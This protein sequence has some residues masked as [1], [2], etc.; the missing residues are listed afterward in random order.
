MSVFAC[1]K[2]VVTLWSNLARSSLVFII[3]LLLT[4]YLLG[5]S[6]VYVMEKN[7]VKVFFVFVFGDSF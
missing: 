7:R 3:A 6:L 1:E 4:N 2:V 5:E